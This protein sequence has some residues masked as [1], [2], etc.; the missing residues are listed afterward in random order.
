MLRRTSESVEMTHLAR[1]P[2]IQDQLLN[3]LYFD[4]LRGWR[5]TTSANRQVA[6]LERG[7]K[8]V[9]DLQDD[10][11]RLCDERMVG[12]VSSGRPPHQLEG[13]GDAPSKETMF[14][15]SLRS[16]V[17]FAPPSN[18]PSR[19]KSSSRVAHAGFERRWKLS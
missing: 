9:R 15:S 4:L 7:T 18:E 2:G 3:S 17:G 16:D 12:K 10:V 5:P 13:T 19:R 6:E 11:E 1:L 14:D 8:R